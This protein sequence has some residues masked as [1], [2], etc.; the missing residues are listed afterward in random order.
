MAA[1]QLTLRGVHVKRLGKRFDE[2][3]QVIVGT[4]GYVRVRKTW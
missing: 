1:M 3:G 2:W 4:E